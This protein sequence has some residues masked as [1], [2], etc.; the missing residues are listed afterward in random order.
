VVCE[1][2]LLGRVVVEM[3]RCW[4]VLGLVGSTGLLYTII[5]SI[6]LLECGGS[7]LQ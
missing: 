1:A 4:D 3:H 6:F 5:Q 2:V 7:S